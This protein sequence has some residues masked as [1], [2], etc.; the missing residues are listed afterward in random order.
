VV[1]ARLHHLG[2][3]LA[4]DDFGTGHSSLQR[5]KLLPVDELKIDR[6][7]VMSMEEDHRDAAIVQAAVDLGR[8]LGLRVV[9]EGVETASA[10]DRLAAKGCDVL[11]GYFL[12]R[13][14]P[15]AALRAWAAEREGA[16][17]AQRLAGGARPRPGRRGSVRKEPRAEQLGRTLLRAAGS[18]QPVRRRRRLVHGG[19][20]SLAFEHARSDPHRDPRESACAQAAPKAPVLRRSAHRRPRERV[21]PYGRVKP[22]HAFLRGPEPSRCTPAWR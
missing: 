6:S 13:P 18:E 22:V 7:F 5:L 11:Q 3:Q 1:L 4:L 20:R 8:R 9:A 15:E 14:L 2:V 19:H 21:F 10:R 12:A 16:S 17:C